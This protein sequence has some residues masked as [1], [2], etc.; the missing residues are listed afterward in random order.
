MVGLSSAIKTRGTE[1]FPAR[2]NLTSDNTRYIHQ[3]GSLDQ[4]RKAVTI[5]RTK[6]PAFRWRPGLLNCYAAAPFRYLSQGHQDSFIEV[7]NL[8]V[9]TSDLRD[10]PISTTSGRIPLGNLARIVRAPIPALNTIYFDGRH[11]IALIV[12]KQPNASTAPVTQAVQS[13]LA[14]TLRQLPQGFHWVDIYDQGHLVNVVGAD[15]TRNLVIGGALAIA[16]MLWVLGAGWDM[17][18]CDQH[19]VIATDGHRWTLL[20]GREPQLDDARRA[21]RGRGLACR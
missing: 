5:G 19:S 8:P 1:P 17:D 6:A 2:L 12:F 7:R 20:C 3:T 9:S 14:E 11:S 21:Y 16:V 4:Y 10:I 15:L 13:A 18:P